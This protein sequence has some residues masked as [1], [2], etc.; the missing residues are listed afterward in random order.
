MWVSSIVLRGISCTIISWRCLTVNR[1]WADVILV[2]FRSVQMLSVQLM[3]LVPCELSSH[4]KVLFC[5]Y[6]LSH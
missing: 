6:Q 1:L 3:V 2:G 4:Y 5:G